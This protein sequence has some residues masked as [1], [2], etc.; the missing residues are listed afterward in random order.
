M[1]LPQ[2]KHTVS[3][4]TFAE[5]GWGMAKFL[6]INRLVPLA[7]NL[8]DLTVTS[9]IRNISNSSGIKTAAPLS[10]KLTGTSRPTT[11]LSDDNVY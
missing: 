1:N 10:R 2:T 6:Y 8:P 3:R 4:Q 11:L 5:V 7:K 9:G